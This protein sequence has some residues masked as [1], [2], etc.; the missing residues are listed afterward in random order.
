[1]L[2]A[3]CPVGQGAF[4]LQRRVFGAVEPGQ[5]YHTRVGAY[6]VAFDGRGNVA[7]VEAPAARGKERWLFL[8]GGG[9]EAEETPEVCIRRECLEETGRIATVGGRVCVGEEYLF[10]PSD[11]A[12]LHVVGQ[13]YRAVLGHQVQEPTEKDH[14]LKWIPIEVCGKQ[15]F[16]HY[17][18]WAVELAW[19]RQKIELE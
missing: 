7:L 11:G 2:I 1:M 13:C 8:P 10:A 9:I 5:P 17:Q 4:L 12:Y 19:E 14:V 6:A 3:L 16:L 18:A 15:M